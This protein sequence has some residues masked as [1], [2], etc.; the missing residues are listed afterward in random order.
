MGINVPAGVLYF[1]S[2]TGP[3]EAAKWLWE[4]TLQSHELPNLRMSSVLA[5]SLS[6]KIMWSDDPLSNIRKIFSLYYQ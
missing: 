1:I 2:R 4:R 6:H 3:L 5:W